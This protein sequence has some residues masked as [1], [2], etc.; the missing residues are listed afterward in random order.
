MFTV[1]A[2]DVLLNS[3]EP[4][5]GKQVNRETGNMCGFP[6]YLFLVYLYFN[7]LLLV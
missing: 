2:D 7:P 4:A 5:V 3:S 1:G 6:V